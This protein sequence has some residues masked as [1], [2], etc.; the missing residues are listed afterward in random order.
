MDASWETRSCNQSWATM[1]GSGCIVNF[2]GVGWGLQIVSHNKSYF[3]QIHERTKLALRHSIAIVHRRW[4]I[5]RA[6]QQWGSFPLSWIAEKTSP[7][8][9]RNCDCKAITHLIGGKWGAEVRVEEKSV[10]RSPFR[11][12]YR[13]IGW[14]CRTTCSACL[15]ESPCCAGFLFCFFWRPFIGDVKILTAEKTHTY[16]HIHTHTHPENSWKNLAK[17]SAEKIVSA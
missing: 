7:F 16:T 6:Y 17:K 11:C 13:H 12:S 15:T 14:A 9:A 10:F 1:K 5:A 3:L 2:W 8:A 4:G